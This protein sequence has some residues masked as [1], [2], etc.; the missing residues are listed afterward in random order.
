[1]SAGTLGF[2]L[3]LADKGF[4]AG[5]QKAGASMDHVKGMAGG[6]QHGLEEAGKE[7]LGHREKV[8]ILRTSL[9]QMGGPL[10]K[11]GEFSRLALDPLTIGFAAVF[12]AVEYYNIAMEHA[13]Q[14]NEEF[15]KSADKV[16]ESVKKVFEA[17]G[18]QHGKEEAEARAQVKAGETPVDMKSE[19][20]QAMDNLLAGQK[21]AAEAAK[22]AVELEKQRIQNMVAAG[23]LSKDDA[24]KRVQTI[25]REAAL[26][27]A[28]QERWD[29]QAQIKLLEF[30]KKNTAGIVNS[31]GTDKEVAGK[32]YEADHRVEKD[33]AVIDNNPAAIA[34]LREQDKQVRKNIKGS[35]FLPDLSGR[36]WYKEDAEILKQIHR[37]E[38]EYKDARKDLA[39]ALQDQSSTGQAVSAHDAGQEQQREIDHQLQVL[40][41]KL[42][43]LPALQKITLPLELQSIDATKAAA[44]LKDLAPQHRTEATSLEKMGFVMG[45]H[46]GGDPQERQISLLQQ[47]VNNTAPRPASPPPPTPGGQSGLDLT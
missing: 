30:Q 35:L 27:R 13:K 14:M 6:M 31:Y 9:E 22:Q 15:E 8:E 38:Q 42:K 36:D 32:K 44:D 5:L 18:S 12:A 11:L 7:V 46:V 43:N 28:N 40:R 21:A 26:R 4:A 19:G 29:T 45:G 20:Q 34:A 1:M 2:D 39:P 3:I 24:A 23:K 10:G 37:K 41:E 47:L 16:G 17:M 25:E 33:K